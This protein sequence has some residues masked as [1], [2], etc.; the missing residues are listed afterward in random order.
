MDHCV[1]RRALS[2]STLIPDLVKDSREFVIGCAIHVCSPSCYKYHSK[3][4]SHICRHGFYHVVTFCDLSGKQVRRRR[5][6]KLLRGCVAVHRDTRYGMAGRVDLYQLHPWECPTNYA[7]LVAMRCN[8]D[9]QDLRRTLPPHMWLPRTE[10]EQEAATLNE[11]N[12]KAERNETVP[13]WCQ[14]SKR[15]TV[16]RNIP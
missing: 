9:V 8:V 12:N 4:A 5:M 7:M 1:V 2:S 14:P 11:V 16:G 6:G 3:G 15:S 13:G 10:L